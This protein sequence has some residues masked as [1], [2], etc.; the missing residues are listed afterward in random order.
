MRRLL[1]LLLLLSGCPEPEPEGPVTPD[2]NG[3]YNLVFTQQDSTCLPPDFTFDDVFAFL[4]QTTPG[5]P[6]TSALFVQ[7]GEQLAITLEHS[8][9]TLTGSIGG[10]G[11]TSVTGACDD[12]T[13]TRSMTLIGTVTDNG[14]SLDFDGNL[15]MD[16][17][18]GAAGI[19]GT[20]DC[21]VDPVEVRGTGTPDAA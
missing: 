12:A 16:I 15:R 6:V 1:F 10:G 13:M 7:D 14:S 11:A 5:V 2:S 17:D 18:G 4:D 8:D 19:D 21:T 3:R 9:C 20:T